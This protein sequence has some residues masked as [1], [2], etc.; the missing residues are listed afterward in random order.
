V[1]WPDGFGAKN[2][3]RNQPGHLIDI[4]A[5]CVDVAGADYP[6]GVNGESIRMMQGK[7]LVPTFA[8]QPFE[9]DALYWEHEGNRAIRIGKW[10]LVSKADD[11]P[12]KWIKN[13]ELPLDMWELY[14][15][16][17]DRI[18]MTNLAATCPDRVKDMAEKWQAWARQ[19][20]VVPK[21]Y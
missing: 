14:D 5:T 4:M 17:A 3:L 11:H 19:T 18:E 12:H 13:D 15:L 16:E 10:K 20:G 8:D 1:H 2:A 6:A 21:P 7:S 9:R